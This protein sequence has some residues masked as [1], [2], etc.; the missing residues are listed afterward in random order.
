MKEGDICLK[1]GEGKLVKPRVF[2]SIF[3]KN[4]PDFI[5]DKCGAP[6]RELPEVEPPSI[7]FK[8]KEVPKKEE[9]EEKFDWKKEILKRPNFSQEKGKNSTLKILNQLERRGNGVSL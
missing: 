3:G 1:C 2:Y 9:K 4:Q 6:S 5:C 7:T 8:K